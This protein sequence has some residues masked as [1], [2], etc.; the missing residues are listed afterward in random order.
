[1]FLAVAK[2]SFNNK[3]DNNFVVNNFTDN[4]F[5]DNHFVDSSF[6][7][8]VLFVKISFVRQVHFVNILW[9]D[10]N[11]FVYKNKH[12]HNLNYVEI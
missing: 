7:R 10:V 9:N 6:R 2:S 8:Q 12:I 4:H 1:M 5:D 11:T 3:I